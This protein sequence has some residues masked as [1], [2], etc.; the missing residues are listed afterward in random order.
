MVSLSII[1]KWIIRIY[2]YIYTHTWVH[3]C[4]YI[5]I[6]GSM[7]IY[8]YILHGSMHHELNLIIVHQD[9]TYSVYYISVG[10]S[11]CFGCR[12]PSSGAHTNVIHVYHTT[13]QYT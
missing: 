13:V 7:H 2:I 6:H 12:H 5:Y 9:A 8:I 3:A 4:I 10:S 1:V 11:T